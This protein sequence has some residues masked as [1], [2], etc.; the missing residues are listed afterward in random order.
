M[1][2]YNGFDDKKCSRCVVKNKISN[3][4]ALLKEKK[5]L[6]VSAYEEAMKEVSS[7][8]ARAEE[9]TLLGIEGSYS[10]DFFQTYFKGMNWQRRMPRA[11]IDEYNILLDMGY[12]FLFNFVDA[13]L[14]LYGFDTYKG[15]YHK[16]F[17]QRKSLPCDI[18]EPFRCLIDRQLLKSFNLGQINEK[19]FDWENDRY[20]LKYENSQKYAEF[21]LSAIIAR[22]ED[23][24]NYV[25][26]FY[27]YA[28]G[29]QKDFPYFTL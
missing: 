15:F 4:L 29:A 6:T 21:F 22:K 10:K 1:K 3:Q 14:R 25:K 16:L 9:K 19:D 26:S 24:F 17:F 12:T 23:I 20:Y 8:I 2:Q 28:M 5:R 11:K 7:K 13:L 27:R 18:M